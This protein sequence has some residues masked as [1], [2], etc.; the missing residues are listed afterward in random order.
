MS[1]T[2]HTRLDQDSVF[3]ADLA[4]CQVRLFNDRNF[5]WLLLIP[6][7]DHIEHFSQLNH[8]QHQQLIHEI[9][10]ADCPLRQVFPHVQKINQGLMGLVVEQFHWHL[11]GRHPQDGLWPRPVWGNVVCEDYTYCEVGVLIPQLEAALMTKPA[12]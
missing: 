5:P 2:L 6:R 4:L 7:L 3:I 10:Q 12:S 8:Q 9:A 11:V 1:F